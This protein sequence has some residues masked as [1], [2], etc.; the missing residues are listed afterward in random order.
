M[1]KGKTLVGKVVCHVQMHT[2]AKK[3]GHYKCKKLRKKLAK[4]FAMTRCTPLQKN[5]A[6]I[7]AEKKIIVRTVV[8][9]DKMH[10]LAKMGPS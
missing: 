8:C 9:H 10:T 2:S 6:T 7:H 5:G 3:W 4:L 1:Q